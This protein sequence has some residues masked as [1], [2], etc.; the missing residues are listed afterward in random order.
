MVKR[1]RSNV[2]G[3]WAFLIG[4]IL[5]TTM[6]GDCNDNS[7]WMLEFE[8]MT[9]HRIG[10]G[11]N[12]PKVAKAFGE[13]V[14]Q[15]IKERAPVNFYTYG[16]HFDS[17]KNIITAVKKQAKG[18]ELVDDTKD[19][20]N[21]EN[22]QVIEGNP[23]G[24]ITWTRMLVQDTVP[25]VDTLDRE[26]INGDDYNPDYELPKDIKTKKDFMSGTSKND[27][28][29]KGDKAYELKTESEDKVEMYV[30]K[31]KEKMRGSSTKTAI[32]WVDGI[33]GISKENKDKIK[34]KLK[35]PVKKEES[36][37]EFKARKLNEEFDEPMQPEDDDCFY[38]PSGPLGSRTSVSC[39]G[40]FIGE[41]RSDEEALQAIKDWQ[42]KN[43]YYP[44]IW[45]VSDHGNAILVD[46]EG[47][48]IAESIQEG[49]GMDVL[50]GAAR[51]AFKRIREK[52][53]GVCQEVMGLSKEELVHWLKD[54]KED[55]VHAMDIV[56][57]MMDKKQLTF[58]EEILSGELLKE[59]ILDLIAKKSPKVLTAA[60]LILMIMGSGQHVFAKGDS[61]E[62]AF[63]KA[64][65]NVEKIVDI[66]KEQGAK[67][68]EQIQ[69]G[70]EKVGHS[71][72][73]G[74]EEVGREI[75][76]GIETNSDEIGFS[77]K[78]GAEEL[79][80]TAKSKAEQLRKGAEE[81]GD[82]AKSKAEQLK[83][84][85]QNFIQK[86]KG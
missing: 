2:V 70:V 72:K 24:K 77:I 81:L 76:K 48:E 61:G 30:K 36:F 71:A 66:V 74:A 32:G 54:N 78:K 27:K 6:A 17:I 11:D 46:R 42:D 63:K 58:E 80:D 65:K 75:K 53:K 56:R 50:K 64:Q 4:V 28:L 13:A 84:G 82:T 41:F 12:D 59:N 19:K 86:K 73:K 68:G 47:N 22:G 67:V 21:E 45:Y 9:S 35:L 37:A 15:W 16:S 7:H 85:F 38:S 20:K 34:K 3:A 8:N 40:K 33:K 23:V 10:F 14:G 57:H 44:N 29:D 31:F 43:N 52:V 69:K 79:G 5:A 25:V 1:H 51:A 49:K 60:A 62:E 18:Y 26:S 55:F 39:G 83:K